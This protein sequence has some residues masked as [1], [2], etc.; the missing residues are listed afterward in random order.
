MTDFEFDNDIEIIEIKKNKILIDNTTQTDDDTCLHNNNLETVNNDEEESRLSEINILKSEIQA[1]KIK[2][3]RLENN[4]K[5]I[6]NLLVMFTK[7]DVKNP[8][9][10]KIRRQL[11]ILINRELRMNYVFPFVNLL[12]NIK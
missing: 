2:N 7:I 11:T 5:D 10:D 6:C 1:L 3:S 9:I 4:F 8:E 12:S